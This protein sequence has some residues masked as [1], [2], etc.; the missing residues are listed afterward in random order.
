MSRTRSTV[1]GRILISAIAIAV[2][3]CGGAEKLWPVKGQVVFVNRSP[4]KSGVIEFSP[5]KRG[6]VAR[7]KIAADGSFELR[8]GDRLGAVAGPH[9]V[10]VIQ[11]AIADGAP[12]HAHKKHSASVVHRKHGRFATSGLTQTVEPKDDNKFVIIV[13]PSSDKFGF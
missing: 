5:P 8:T 12:Q 2:A 13:E 7:S 9:Q 11:V 3:G 10:A 4:V 6:P 1:A